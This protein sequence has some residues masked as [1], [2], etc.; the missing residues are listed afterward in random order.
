VIGIKM[1][2]PTAIRAIQS[3]QFEELVPRSSSGMNAK[4]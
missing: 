2:D 1:N 3:F 4:T